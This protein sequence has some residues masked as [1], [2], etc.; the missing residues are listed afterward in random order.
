[1]DAAAASVTVPPMQMQTGDQSNR[2]AIII[3]PRAGSSKILPF[4]LVNGAANA[5]SQRHADPA[6][7]TPV[8][9]HHLW[10]PGDLPK[11]KPPVPLVKKVLKN[12][13]RKHLL[14][15]RVFMFFR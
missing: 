15:F 12:F 14:Q 11:I 6:E 8:A 7:S 13:D 3:S 9:H 5:G 1:M 10:H 2:I 4:E